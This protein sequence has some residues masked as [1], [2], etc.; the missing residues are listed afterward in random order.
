MKSFYL[1]FEEE[2]ATNKAVKDKRPRRRWVQ[3]ATFMNKEAV[4]AYINEQLIWSFAK[5]SEALKKD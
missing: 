1:T 4:D 5:N 2:E 3:F